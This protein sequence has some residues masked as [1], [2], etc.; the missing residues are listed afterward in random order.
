MPVM[1]LGLFPSSHSCGSIG[2]KINLPTS[3]GKKVST[4]KVCLLRKQDTDFSSHSTEVRCPF[5]P[6]VPRVGDQN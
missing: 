6:D 2:D 5:N 3:L 1:L 4:K